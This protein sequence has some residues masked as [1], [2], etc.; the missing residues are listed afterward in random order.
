[1]EVKEAIEKVKSVFDDWVLEY[2]C[3]ERTTDEKE[4]EKNE[5]I[6]LLQQSQ[7]WGKLEKEYGGIPTTYRGGFGTER[8]GHDMEIKEIMKEIEQN[9]K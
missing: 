6:S 8:V 4:E 7:M 2:S 3:S 5:I 9:E 1:M